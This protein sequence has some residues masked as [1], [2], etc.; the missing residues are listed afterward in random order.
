MGAIRRPRP[1]LA[2]ARGGRRAALRD[3]DLLARAARRRPAC[4]ADGRRPRPA[5]DRP[6]RRDPDGRA[7]VVVVAC[8]RGSRARSPPTSSACASPTT[9][10]RAV[11]LTVGAALVLAAVAVAWT[12]LGDL[13]GS[14]VIPPELDTRTATA[15]GFD[16]PVRESVD[17]GPG[18]L[19]SAL[20]RCVLPVVAGEILLRG[21]VFPALSGVARA[22][23]GRADRLRPVRRLRAALR[24]A[25]DRRPLDAA[26]P[27]PVPP[28]RR[29]G[30]AARRHRARV[31]RRG[32]RLG[33]SAGAGAGRRGGAR[34]RLRGASRWALPP[35]PRSRGGA[36]RSAA[37]ARQRG[38]RA[39]PAAAL[40]VLAL[41]GCGGDGAARAGLRRPARRRR[42]GGQARRAPGRQRSRRR[43][44]IYK[45]RPTEG[46]AL[47]Y[48]VTV[49]NTSSDAIEVTGVKADEDRDGAFVPERVEAPPSR[50]R[51]GPASR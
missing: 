2:P 26:R 15:R 23:P 41:A 20:A 51:R 33:V 14:L 36:R 6:A 17:W 27:A 29:H 21:F 32:R 19:A 44:A 50:S 47:T 8:S 3:R 48:T 49:R 30:L 45:V 22:G 11:L 16:L 46:D 39:A 35:R 18:L 25:G 5:G 10:P 42:G 38:V 24:L 28:L 12:V 43:R 31:G 37:A 13:E 40:L 9:L 1:R 34:R 4:A 7:I